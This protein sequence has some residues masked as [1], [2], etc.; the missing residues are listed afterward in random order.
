MIRVLPHGWYFPHWDSFLGPLV[1]GSEPAGIEATGI[2]DNAYLS[3]DALF[4][5]FCLDCSASLPLV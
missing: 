4:K 1:Q 2:T 5:H 3:P